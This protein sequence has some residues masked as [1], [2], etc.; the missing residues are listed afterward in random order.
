MPLTFDKKC[1]P[2]SVL[3]YTGYG[4]KA[5]IYEST[6]ILGIDT[7]EGVKCVRVNSMRT[8]KNEFTATWV[9]QDMSGN[10]YY[11]KYWDGEDPGPVVL[12]KKG[13]LS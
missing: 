12:G 3:F 8:E 4:T 9:A 5:L 10:V 7:V 6:N 1:A 13:L 2:G 11:L